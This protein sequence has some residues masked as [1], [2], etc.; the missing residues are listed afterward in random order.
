MDLLLCGL[1]KGRR[2]ESLS[3]L[4]F[5]EFIIIL[6]PDLDGTGKNQMLAKH[7]KLPSCDVTT[8]YLYN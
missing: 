3:R 2:I 5:I 7:R 1:P 6:I 4:A 8:V